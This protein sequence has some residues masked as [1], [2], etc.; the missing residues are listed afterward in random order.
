MGYPFGYTTKE[1]AE[2]TQ[3]QVIVGR[4]QELDIDQETKDSLVA[5]ITLFVDNV[6]KSERREFGEVLA[7]L[8]SEYSPYY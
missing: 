6:K 7:K 3:R 2:A 8:T 5:Q 4:I 1:E